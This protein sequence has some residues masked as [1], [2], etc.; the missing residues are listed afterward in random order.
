[1]VG[2]WCPADL[3]GTEIVEYTGFISGESEYFYTWGQTA[4]TW[5]DTASDSCE[6]WG[7]HT[8]DGEDYVPQGH[9]ATFDSA[10]AISEMQGQLELVATSGYAVLVGIRWE[11][12]WD[13]GVWSWVDQ[14]DDALLS[15]LDFCGGAEVT[16]DDVYEGLFIG[17]AVDA[18]F[19]ED[20]LRDMRLAMVLDDTGE[21]CLGLPSD[22]GESSADS[23]YTPQSGH[24]LCERPQPDPE[25]YSE[26]QSTGT[27]ADAD[28]K[29]Q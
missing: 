10:A 19:L 5:Y 2:W 8:P 17:D 15:G 3:Y 1:M 20:T 12:T 27:A 25:E 9:L 26:T 21:W 23:G 22:V 28:A 6:S 14:S 16:P 11:G 7:A 4:P 13:E 24:F 18:L 29:P